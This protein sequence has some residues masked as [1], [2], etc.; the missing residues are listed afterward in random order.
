LVFI[1]GQKIWWE[2]IQQFQLLHKTRSTAHICEKHD[3]IDKT[4]STKSI[5]TP[6]EE[7][8]ATASQ[9]QV[10]TSSA[11]WFPRYTNGQQ[12]NRLAHDEPCN[13]IQL[14]SC[15]ALFYCHSVI[16]TCT[17]RYNYVT[18]VYLLGRAKPQTGFGR[19]KFN[20]N[21]IQGHTWDSHKTDKKLL[22]SLYSST[23][24]PINSNH[25]L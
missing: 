1:V 19:R 20:P 5:A 23:P 2:F 21:F 16:N 8:R 12:T 24:P 6:P 25:Q 22:G 15:S 18:T 13:F 10:F 17:S 4:G 9:Q 11:V 3:V 14:D 7:D